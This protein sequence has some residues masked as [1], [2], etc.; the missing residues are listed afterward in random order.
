[1]KRD[2]ASE[3]IGMAMGRLEEVEREFN[4][5]R[6]ELETLMDID[7][8]CFLE[9]CPD[10]C[11]AGEV[12][13]NCTRPIFIKKDQQMSY[14]CQRGKKRPCTSILCHKNNMGVYE[15]VSIGG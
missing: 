6:E 5:S 8:L 3:R 14:H 10:V 15:S 2:D 9:N 13:R 12:C 4:A 1:M 7:G 11:M